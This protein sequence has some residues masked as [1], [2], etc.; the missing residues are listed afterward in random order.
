MIRFWFIWNNR[1]LSVCRTGATLYAD[2]GCS[3]MELKRYGVW[4]SDSVA[5]GYVE[6][7]LVGKQKAAAL[8]ESCLSADNGIKS[9]NNEHCSGEES[10]ELTMDGPPQKRRKLNGFQDCSFE[11]CTF[12]FSN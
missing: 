10:E 6:E 5:Q 7:S 2:S 3:V 4:K 12:N 11:S 9:E 1:K 8:I